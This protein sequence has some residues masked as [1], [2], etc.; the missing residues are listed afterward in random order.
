MKQLIKSLSMFF[1]AAVVLGSCTSAY[2]ST[3]TPDDVYASSEKPGDEHNV[4]KNDRKPTYRQYSDDEY[5]DFEDYDDRYLRMK[6]K[7]RSRWSDLDDW[8]YYGDRYNFSYFNNWSYWNDPFYWNNPWSP[9]SYWGM[10]SP[11]GWRNNYYPWYTGSYWGGGLYGSWYNNY[12]GGGIYNSWYGNG[13][14]GFYDP[15]YNGW[16]YYP[17]WGIGASKSVNYGARGINAN[18]YNRNNVTQGGRGGISTS[19]NSTYRNTYGV[20]NNASVE[21][22]T[23]NS[24]R[25]AR[26]NTLRSR[27][28]N[29]SNNNRNND[30][31][32]QSRNSS[33]TIENRSS[34]SN[35]SSVGSSSGSNSS[36]SGSGRGGTG[37]SSG[38][39][40]F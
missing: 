23:G 8:Y 5:E 9:V 22:S 13:W 1:V 30:Y 10:Y 2:Q 31:S 39:R 36:S 32:T 21:T 20:R 33:S 27:Y 12:W 26:M 34:S 38:G 4:A 29:N 19:N 6:V 17:G 25:D 14:N 18:T 3:G 37:S 11:W 16:G 40:R 7:N 35:N 28:N 24:G 15:W